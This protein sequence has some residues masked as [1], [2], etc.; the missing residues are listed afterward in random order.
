MS[1]DH[2]HHDDAG[3]GTHTIRASKGGGGGKLLLGAL[4]AVLIAGGGYYAWQTYGQPNSAQTAYND[5][6]ATDPYDDSLR[7]GPVESST[8]DDLAENTA[9]EPASTAAPPTTT[10]RTPAPRS[11]PVPEATIGVTPA[12][13]SEE[14]V[15]A[16]DGDDI[17]V[18]AVPRPIWVRT[19]SE[20]RLTSLYPARALERGRE[21]EARLHCTVLAGGALDCASVEST[22]GFSNAA[23]RVSRT[24]RHAAQRAD[25]ADATGTPVNLRVVFRI[26]DETRRG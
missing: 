16:N 5:S 17:V 13:V 10:R 11:E 8:S 22:P 21:G 25:G 4:A 18:T 9:V 15:A 19:P 24:L 2:D 3:H 26:D 1:K 23:I 20:R 6:Y 12:S 14:E 7:A